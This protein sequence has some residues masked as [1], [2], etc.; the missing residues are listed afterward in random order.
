MFIIGRVQVY[1]FGEQVS[2]K[3]RM[4]R[5]E[6]E[7]G[8]WCGRVKFG[9]SGPQSPI[10]RYDFGTRGFKYWSCGSSS[11]GRIGSTRLLPQRGCLRMGR[12]CRKGSIVR[13]RL[14][15]L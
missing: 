8:H 10:E 7:L 5:P 11:C 4:V 12:R 15:A 13:P 2:L 6:D 9:S 3:F 1:G 14:R